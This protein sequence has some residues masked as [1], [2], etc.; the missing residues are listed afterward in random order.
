MGTVVKALSL[1]DHFSRTRPEIGL[2]DMA[3]L[4]GLNK[5]TTYRLL[6]ELQQGGFVEQTGSGREYRLGPAVLRLAALREAA[7]PLRDMA[8]RAL[9]SLSD[10]TDETAHLSLLQGDRLSMLSYAYSPRHGTRVT[11]EDAQVLAF[12]AT[13]SGLAVLAFSPPEMIDRILSAPLDKR[14]EDTLTDPAAIRAVL[15]G[16]RRTG[17][18]ESVGGFEK[19]VHS[20]AVPLFDAHSRVIGAM[21]VAAPVARMTPA[22]TALIRRELWQNATGLTRALGGFPP[23]GFAPDGFTAQ[24]AAE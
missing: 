21:A 20:H 3:R 6:S 15:A 2:S 19:D 7:V 5:A 1:L 12:H 24:E 4:A 13:S 23:D 11:M 22:L 8:A 14:T 16:V 18:A 9:Q 10:A 17:I